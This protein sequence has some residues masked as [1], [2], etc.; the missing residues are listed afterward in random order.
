MIDYLKSSISISTYTG[1]T[2]DCLYCI[3]GGIKKDLRKIE[4]IQTEDEAINNLLNYQFFIKDISVIS[5]NNRTDPF[6][7]VEISNSTLLILKKL[8]IK[9]I[10]NPILLITKMKVDSN[11]LKE[12]DLLDLNVIFF[13]SYS[14]LKKPLEGF[15]EEYRKSAIINISENLK[16]CTKIHYI[17]PIIPHYNDDISTITELISISKEYFDG[18]V[19]SGLRINSVI[20]DNFISK[21]VDIDDRLINQ[22]SEH[23]FLDRE[24]MLNFLYV[25][26]RENFYNIFFHTSCAISYFL[27]KADYNC[28]YGGEK[29]FVT[30]PN[31]ERCFEYFNN[32]NVA[33]KLYLLN[34]KIDYDIV[35]KKVKIKDVINQERLSYYM[36]RSGVKFY[37]ENVQ[38][39][40]SEVLLEKV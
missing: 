40:G 22:K 35:N 8:E 20:Q 30:C 13:Y 36:H 5:I 6:L 9:K 12:I 39:S 4:R 14:A 37:S 34:E 23:K 26:K 11:I 2:N 27:S 17:R 19:V 15:S 29:C 16:K 7:N 25:S 28:S 31:Y 3:V 33:H 24:T 1:C 18:A 10:K 32:V 21:N 38:K